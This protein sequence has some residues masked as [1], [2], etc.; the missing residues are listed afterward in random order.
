MSDQPRTNLFV[1]LHK[2][3]SEVGHLNKTGFSQFGKYNYHAA[4][5]VI[6]AIGQALVNNG[7]LCIPSIVGTETS[8]FE[9]KQGAM[10]W[11]DDI[12]MQFTLIH[13]ASGETWTSDYFATGND[14]GDKGINKAATYAHKY[15]L[16]KLFFSGVGN[17][18]GEADASQQ[19]QAPAQ[20]TNGKPHVNM[21]AMQPDGAAAADNPFDANDAG[22]DAIDGLRNK[23]HSIGTGIWPSASV[24]TKSRHE[25]AKSVSEGRTQS[26]K[27]LNAAELQ[28]AITI[29]DVLTQAKR[30]FGPGFLREA[31]KWCAG[32]DGL[33]DAVLDLSAADATRVLTTF[34]K[35][36]SIDEVEVAA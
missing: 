30:I 7:L 26:S 12:H 2:A 36:D 33:A 19:Q 34:R 3:I 13:A 20:R 17:E 6:P 15:F 31:N 18:D 22:R 25:L 11:R 29:L 21:A 1:A 10:N 27:Q 14:S 35:Q 8:T 16:L 28:H 24:W 23:M 9:T 5:V 32:K 4:D